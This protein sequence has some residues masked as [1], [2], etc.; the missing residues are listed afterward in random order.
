MRKRRICI[1][2]AALMMFALAGCTGGRA[3]PTPE[4][5]P[6]Q[7]AAPTPEA[8]PDPTPE[9]T[10]TPTP[11]PAGYPIVTK[12]PTDETVE[13]GGSCWFVANYLS[14]TWAVWHFV[15]PDGSQDLTYKEIG[16]QFPTLQIR[17]GN[18]SEMKLSN[19]PLEMNGWRVYCQYTNDL[20]STN[21]G[22]AVVT[23]KSASGT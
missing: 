13:E 22:T 20:G 14:A 11:P 18:V 12:S 4:P 16:E 23:V 8:T 3:A 5:A 15:S 7:T 21:P 9:P 10:P 17:G 19:I 6:T 1:L 2:L